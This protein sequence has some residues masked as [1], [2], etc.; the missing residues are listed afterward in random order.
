MVNLQTLVVTDH[1]IKD[2]SVLKNFSKLTFIKISDFPESQF[3]VLGNLPI[4]GLMLP[5]STIKTLGTLATK[6]LRY[7]DLSNSQLEDFQQLKKFTSL[8]CLSLE[9]TKVADLSPLS[10]LRKL[11]DLDLKNTSV[12]DLS[13]LRSCILESIDL[14]GTDVTDISPIVGAENICLANCSVT[15]LRPLQQAGNISRLDL[16]GLR[17]DPEHLAG[18]YIWFLKLSHAELISDFPISAFSLNLSHSNFVRVR[19]CI[20]LR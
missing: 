5:N 3:D 19:A 20:E 2:F 4:R 12:V 13:P 17:V 18:R 16:S 15:D 8:R 14:S 7:L 1:Q 6:K 11:R 10:A 9:G